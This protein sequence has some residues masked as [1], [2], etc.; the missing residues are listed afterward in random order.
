MKKIVSLLLLFVLII[1]CF[2]DSPLT[3]TFF[4]GAYSD[5]ALINQILV[6]RGK[7]DKYNFELTSPMLKYLDDVSVS[8]DKKIA[9]INALGWGDE[10]NIAIYKKHLTSKYSLGPDELEKLLILD[11][12]EESMVP[13]FAHKMSYDDL[14]VL[15]YLQI[16]GN[17]FEP[18]RGILAIEH[19]FTNNMQ[20]EAT[21]WVYALLAG[22]MYLDLNWCEVYLSLEQISLLA[23]TKDILR[24]EAKSAIWEYIGLYRDSCE[25]MEV[26]EN[27]SSEPDVF[28][29]AQEF[30]SV[31]PVYKKQD[32]QIGDQKGSSVD[33]EILNSSK[34]A[35][36]ML[37]N[38]ILYDPDNNGT[39]LTI[40]VRNNGTLT[41]NETN[42]M[43]HNF[44][45]E[46][47]GFGEIYYQVLIPPIE[48]GKT[49]K[50][51]VKLDEYWIYD[52]NAHFEIRLD[53]DG[54]IQ[55][56]N[57]ENNIRTFYEAG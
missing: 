56:T 40:E 25:Q 47:D 18:T 35:D 27:A 50:V 33:L 34:P 1:P 44:P 21:G 43:F 26:T 7:G 28:E 15:G 13:E 46:S 16:M 10:S 24:D 6:D 31:D 20:S 36:A 23:Y 29:N 5:Q 2:G 22:Q 14:T 38:W 30:Y 12:T 55:E 37:N 41:S 45:D 51:Y 48:A 52:P 4:A 3:S 53:F 19:A 54:N 49:I 57:E 8:L 17:Y 42:L 32:L 9:L 39:Q 11:I